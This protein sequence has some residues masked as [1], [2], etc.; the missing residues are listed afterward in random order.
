[1]LI[2]DVHRIPNCLLQ[3]YSPQQL[4]LPQPCKIDKSRASGLVIKI[5]V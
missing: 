3:M 1:M 5:V 4:C 2:A